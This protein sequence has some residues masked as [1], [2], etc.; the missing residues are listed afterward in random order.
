MGIISW[1]SGE[2][3]QL[4]WQH[5][6]HVPVPYLLVSSPLRPSDLLGVRNELR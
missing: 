6:F 2:P 5:W 1:V 4:G 3:G